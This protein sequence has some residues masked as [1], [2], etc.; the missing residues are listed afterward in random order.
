MEKRIIT[1]EEYGHLINKLVKQIAI[2]EHIKDIKNVLGIYRGGLPI[3]VHLSHYF[4]WDFVEE[5]HFYVSSDI[6]RG[7]L[8]IVDDIADT[9]KTLNNLSL[10]YSSNESID[11]LTATLFYKRRSVFKP[12]FFVEETDKWIVF[13]WERLD[14]IPNRPE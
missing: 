9:G 13:P 6:F 4:S 12:T 7:N 1:Y 3:A 11:W 5:H 2:S 14:E 10:D 8:L